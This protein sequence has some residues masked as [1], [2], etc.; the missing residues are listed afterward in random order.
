MKILVTYFEPF[1]ADDTNSSAE[2][3]RL[4]HNPY[5]CHKIVSCLLPVS[6]K[7]SA[8]IALA[9]IEEEH[10]DIVLCLG[11]A[12]GRAV[13]SLERLAI[14]IASSK[15]PDCDDY[16]PNNHKINPDGPDA[17]MTGVDV[18][19]LVQAMK[20]KGIP[21]QVSNSAGTFVCNSLY[22]RLLLRHPSL[23]VIFIH[24]P[25]TPRQA[26]ARAAATP[27]MHPSTCADAIRAIIDNINPRRPTV[28][29]SMP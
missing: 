11:Q 1:G 8:D 26:S 22:Y 25:L 4:L 28:S 5:R 17:V 3:V 21:C 16:S 9:K 7:R 19:V 23:P 20:E 15:S 24:L 27:S 18:A 12:A 13:V 2:A 6:F 29:T 10:P 14:N